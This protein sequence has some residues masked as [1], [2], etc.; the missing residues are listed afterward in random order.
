MVSLIFGRIAKLNQMKKLFSGS[1]DIAKEFFDSH[2]WKR[3]VSIS[4]LNTL[5]G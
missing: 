3:Y 4:C 1:I 5:D 2:A